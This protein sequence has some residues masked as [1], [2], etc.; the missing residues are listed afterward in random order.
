MFYDKE[1]TGNDR[2]QRKGILLY[3]IMYAREHRKTEMGSL[4]GSPSFLTT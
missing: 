2:M 1:G 4:I 3:K